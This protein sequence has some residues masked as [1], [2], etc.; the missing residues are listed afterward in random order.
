MHTY[1]LICHGHRRSDGARKA[2]LCFLCFDSA[3]SKYGAFRGEQFC[4]IDCT[5]QPFPADEYVLLLK[6]FSHL[7]GVAL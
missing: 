1:I 3:A 4:N 7:N 5:V 2:C 6:N